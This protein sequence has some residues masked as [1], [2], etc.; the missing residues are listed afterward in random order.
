MPIFAPYGI[1]TAV[2]IFLAG[3]ASLG[4]VPSLLLLVTANGANG[5]DVGQE[6]SSV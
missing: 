2:M 4:V 6:K 5:S 3:L 1:L